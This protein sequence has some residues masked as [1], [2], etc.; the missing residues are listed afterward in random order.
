[1]EVGDHIF[2]FIHSAVCSNLEENCCIFFYENCQS[3]K[4]MYYLIFPELLPFV[5]KREV[6]LFKI[7]LCLPH[8]EILFLVSFVVK[9]TN[10]YT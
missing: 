6:C 1:M 4:K 8:V 3:N 9:L 2:L 7:K 10:V 5:E